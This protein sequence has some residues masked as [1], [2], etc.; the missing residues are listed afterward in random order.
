MLTKTEA[1]WRHLL[2]AALD[3]GSRRTSI[4]NIAEQLGI[5]PTTIHR[6]LERPREIGAVRGGRPGLRVLDPK[7]LLLL[8]AGR[9]DL[10]KDIVYQTHVSGPMDWIESGLTVTAIPTAYTAFVSR[11]GRNT[12]ADYDQVVVYADA[13]EVQLRFPPRRGPA[14]L[15]VLE[16]D[17]WLAR[18]GR[19]A[20]LPQ[21]YVDLFNLPTWQAQ[22]FLDRLNRE[23]MLGYVA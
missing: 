7:R 11:A 16:P 4:S 12:V 10:A 9:R 13:A 1:V 8:W 22:R 18:Y 6:A 21:M 15:I 3:E 23:V 17:P 5:T 19:M 2:V 20:S 14:N